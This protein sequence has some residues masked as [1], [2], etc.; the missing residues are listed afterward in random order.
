M[1]TA[2]KMEY[3]IDKPSKITL[4]VVEGNKSGR[5]MTND[6]LNERMYYFYNNGGP[7]MDI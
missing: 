1:Q 4:K 2:K 6:Y 7:V 5:K 3:K